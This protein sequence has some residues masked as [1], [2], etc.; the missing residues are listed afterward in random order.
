MLVEKAWLGFF[1]SLFPNFF[2]D[3]D[4]ND[5]IEDAKKYWCEMLQSTKI[6]TRTIIYSDFAYQEFFGNGTKD[7]KNSI[8]SEMKNKLKQLQEQRLEGDKPVFTFIVE[9]KPETSDKPETSF[10][11]E[12]KG[13]ETLYTIT[14]LDKE[15]ANIF[16]RVKTEK[17]TEFTNTEESEYNHFFA[18]YDIN[19]NIKI[20]RD[21]EKHAKNAPPEERAKAK[22][23]RYL[24]MDSP[25][26]QRA[27]EERISKVV[28]KEHAKKS[29][30]ST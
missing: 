14:K 8:L 1:I 16:H 20:F 18:H 24:G 12:L 30:S 27:L 5:T 13:Y 26:Y 6:G 4:R 22:I 29:A 2:I 17:D 3:K 25:R 21:E 7:N 15:N 28:E 19:G 10:L 23:Y 11:N 9:Y